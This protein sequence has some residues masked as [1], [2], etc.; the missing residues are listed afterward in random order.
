MIEILIFVYFYLLYTYYSMSKLKKCP[1]RLQFQ[2]YASCLQNR[3]RCEHIQEMILQYV[4]NCQEIV[5]LTQKLT[6]NKQKTLQI[7]VAS[8][9]GF[10]FKFV[11][12]VKKLSKI[13]ILFKIHLFPSTF[14]SRAVC[15]E[16]QTACFE[17]HATTIE[18]TWELVLLVTNCS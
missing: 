2:I 18:C 1:R 4:R 13:N 14:E 6:R 9:Q 12:V 10:F 8:F 11:N 5:R 17:S 7:F 3:R 15:I 16:S